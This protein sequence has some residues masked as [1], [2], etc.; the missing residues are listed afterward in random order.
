M[1][2]MTTSAGASVKSES[3]LAEFAGAALEKLKRLPD[4][5]RAFFGDLTLRY[6]QHFIA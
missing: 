2:S 3:Q 6:I 5:V 1:S 4:K